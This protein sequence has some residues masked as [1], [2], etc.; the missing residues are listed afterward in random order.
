MLKK[1]YLIICT[2][3]LFQWNL[4]AK[5]LLTDQVIY[6]EDAKKDSTTVACSGMCVYKYFF[7]VD[8]IVRNDSPEKDV[9]IKWNYDGAPKHIARAYYRESLAN[10]YEKW[11]V[12][13][14]YASGRKN[15]YPDAKKFQFEA[16][17]NMNGRSYKS[18][19]GKIYAMNQEVYPGSPT[20]MPLK[21]E[22]FLDKETGLLKLK[23][24][25]YF[26][27]FKE[28]QHLKLKVI[29]TNDNWDTQKIEDLTDQLKFFP[30]ETTLTFGEY[31]PGEEPRTVQLVFAYE[32]N[33]VTFWQKNWSTNYLIYLKPQLLTSNSSFFIRS[34][35]GK[36]YSYETPNTALDQSERLSAYIRSALKIHSF[37]YNFDNGEWKDA[38][39]DYY[40]EVQFPYQLLE[41]GE[42]QLSIQVLM[43]NEQTYNWSYSFSVIKTLQPNGYKTY[44]FP[45]TSEENKVTRVVY[46]QGMVFTLDDQNT[47]NSYELSDTEEFELI[48]NDIEYEQVPGFM[49]SHLTIDAQ[50][51]MVLVGTYNNSISLVR[52][53]KDGSLDE[54]FGF[55]GLSILDKESSSFRNYLKI[56]SHPKGYFVLQTEHKTWQEDDR[57][58]FI[59]QSGQVVRW[60]RIKDINHNYAPVM[61]IIT[62]DDRTIL[63][64]G[65]TMQEVVL[66][67]DNYI[68]LVNDVKIHKY[69]RTF[70]NILN[71]PAVASTKDGGIW[72]GSTSYLGYILP[73]GE[74]DY[75]YYSDMYDNPEVRMTR[76]DGIIPLGDK[77]LVYN[78]ETQSFLELEKSH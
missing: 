18:E 1:L 20:S 21:P 71:A 53:L 74:V 29:Y 47:L 4:I 5:P 33:D 72:L 15:P 41:E 16:E 17:V 23:S 52:Y 68:Q 25:G 56:A 28:A 62:I 58:V 69:K 40:R 22:P 73:N 46:Q 9:F 2:L 61:D 60:H 64:N 32:V 78:G 59:D 49:V 75:Y 48:P 30:E 19:G 6:V 14:K 55:K 11:H 38:K 50:G 39:G 24:K 7:W 13:I 66:D 70:S 51:L 26:Y 77:V 67:E 43:N 8:L 3:F 44:G 36:T 10:N 57:L 31:T 35:L 37:K 54:S 12:E 42:H 63:F 27:P 65:H 45:L 34:L 76:V